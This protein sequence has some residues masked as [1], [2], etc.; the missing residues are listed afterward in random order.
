[1]PF[2]LVSIDHC[3]KKFFVAFLA[4]GFD[5]AA[6]FFINGFLFKIQFEPNTL[7]F[8][9]F[10]K[11]FPHQPGKIAFEQSFDQGLVIDADAAW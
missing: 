9:I 3:K 7:S 8:F 1:M 10:A 5:G 2:F 11:G 4:H 6:S